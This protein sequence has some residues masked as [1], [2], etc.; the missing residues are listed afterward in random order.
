MAN[1]YMFEF[2]IDKTWLFELNPSYTTAQLNKINLLY[3]T[4]HNTYTLVDGLRGGKI[5]QILFSRK[6]LGMEEW[7]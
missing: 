7:F 5:F 3:H 2:Q 4:S 1:C 6:C